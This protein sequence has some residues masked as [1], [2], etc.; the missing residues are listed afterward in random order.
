MEGMLKVQYIKNIF[1]VFSCFGKWYIKGILAGKLAGILKVYVLKVSSRH[2]KV[3]FMFKSMAYQR[4]I[5]GISNDT[6]KVN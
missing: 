3:I 5:L 2:T 4:Q 1:K 6:L